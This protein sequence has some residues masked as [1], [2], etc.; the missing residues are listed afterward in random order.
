MKR[1]WMVYLLIGMLFTVLLAGCGKKPAVGEESDAPADYKGMMRKWKQEAV[2]ET[3]TCWYTSDTDNQWLSEAAKEFEQ[4]YGIKVNPVYYDGVS[5][6]DDMNQANLSGSGPDVYIMGNDQLELARNSGMLAENTVFDDTFWKEHYPETAKKALTYQNRQYGYPV[7][8]DTYCLVYDAN[9]L[10]NAPASIDDILAFL[11]EYEDTG[12]TKAIFRWDVADP[13]INTMFIASYAELFG[14]NGDDGTVFRVNQEKS[15]AAMEYFQSLSAYL[16]MD[17]SN[18]SHDTVINRI[19]DKTLV[20]GL[21]KSDILPVLYEMNKES[22]AD[23]QEEL[24]EEAENGETEEEQEETKEETNYQISYVPSLTA[25]LSSTTLSTT[26]GAFVNPY[27]QDEAAGNMF[28]L[29][30]SYAHPEKQ[31]AGNGRLP[32]INQQDGFDAMQSVLY[33]QYLNSMPVPKV[34][35]LGD[36][37]TESGIAFDAIWSGKDAGEQLDWLQ[38]TMEQKIK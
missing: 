38:K 23:K 12:S 22:S 4:E 33:A 3:L 25:E 32:V 16:W 37:L 14:D 7:Y 9:L 6:F 34:M 31:Y 27:A 36:Y 8:F 15:V 10:E 21:C 26:Y 17:K 20:L 28:A 30:L 18:I 1:K 5:L 35:V 24:P 29:Y 19:K 13:Y 11:D 2:S